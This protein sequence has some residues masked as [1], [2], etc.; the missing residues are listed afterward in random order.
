VVSTQV[1]EVALCLDF[2][3]GASETA[4]IEAIAQRAGRVNRRGRHPDGPVE[5]RIHPA[6]S[7]LPYEQDALTAAWTAL[8]RTATSN[9]MISEQTI[10]T[11]LTDVYATPW[12]QQWAQTARQSRDEFAASFLTFRKPFEDRSEFADGLDQD[13]DT[14]H[15]L[16][17]DDIEEYRTL[18]DKDG[19]DPLL[20]EGLL[21]PLRYGPYARLRRDQRAHIDEHLKVPVVDVPYSPETGLDPYDDA[22]D[23]RRADTAQ[24]AKTMDTVL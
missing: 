18:A 3:R 16:H 23:G 2:D 10:E 12:G 22:G 7:P 9:P 21:I 20:A 5:F 17:T 13:F 11:W 14:V 6:A 24:P 4:P 15:V 1:L 8:Q 19:G